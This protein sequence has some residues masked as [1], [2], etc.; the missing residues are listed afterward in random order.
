M[1]KSNIDDGFNPELVETAQFDGDL[2]IPI[3]KDTNPELPTKVIPFSRRGESSDNNE[4]LIFYEHDKTFGDVVQNPDL[5]I[6]EFRRFKGI[7]SLDNSVFW[8]SPLI[9]QIGNVYKSRAIAHY[10]QTKGINV[11][12]NCR[13][14]DERSYTRCVLPEKFAFLG[15]PK[16]S[17]V[18]IG[19]YGCNQGKEEKHHLRE[20]L[21]SM[22][23][24]VQPRCVIVYGSMPSIVFDEFKGKTRFIQFDDWTTTRKK[25]KDKWEQQNQEDI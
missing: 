7:I 15:I 24:E 2:E 11:I 20:G 3:V 12:V 22:I 1:K 23:E 4:Y 8:D 19:T 13:W 9:V 16:H 17:V 6:E 25:V 5:Y 18:S 14:G 21:R 10:F